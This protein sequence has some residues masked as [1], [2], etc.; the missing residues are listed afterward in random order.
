VAATVYIIRFLKDS[1]NTRRHEAFIRAELDIV[2]YV[3][4]KILN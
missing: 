3:N 1:I 2:I 4:I